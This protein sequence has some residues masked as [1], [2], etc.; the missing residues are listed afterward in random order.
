MVCPFGMVT[1]TLPKKV[2]SKIT[3]L[4][5]FPLPSFFTIP[6][7]SVTTRQQSVPGVNGILGYFFPISKPR[8]APR[9]ELSTVLSFKAATGFFSMVVLSKLLDCSIALIGVGVCFV[10]PVEFLESLI[11]TNVS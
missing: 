3:L 7:F 5:S 4:K 8:V 6:D 9:L 11:T 10:F 2:V 1:F